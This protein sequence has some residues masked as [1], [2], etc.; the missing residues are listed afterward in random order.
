MPNMGLMFGD[1]GKYLLDQ[2]VVFDY[3]AKT[4]AWKGAVADPG[5]PV[6]IVHAPR[7]VCAGRSQ[8]RPVKP[9]KGERFHEGDR[10]KA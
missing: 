5:K 3:S 9:E 1:A 4:W 8:N 6:G 7:G 2:S 10:S